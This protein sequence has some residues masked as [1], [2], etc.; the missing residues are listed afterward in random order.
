MANYNFRPTNRE[1]SFLMPPS[2]KEWLPEDDLVWFVIDAVK[3]IDLRPFYRKYRQDGKGNTAYEPAMMVMLL[4]YAYCLGVRSI[5]KIERLC[6]VD[7]GFRVIAGNQGPDHSTLCRFRQGNRKHIGEL[8]THILQLCAE[9]GLVKLGLVALDGVKIKANAA[10]SANRG[11]SSIEKEVE[12][13]L[14]EAEEI[15]AAEDD[16]YGKGKRGDELPEEL[17]ERSSRLQR[18][19]EAK[20][21][22]ERKQDEE[23]R[24]QEEM[25][26]AREEE[27]KKSGK[28]KRGRKPKKPEEAVNTQTKANITDPESRI[29][30]KRTGY[31]QAYNSQLV[32]T[33]DQIIIAADVTQEENDKKQLHPMLQQAKA[34]LKKAGVGKGIRTLLADAGYWSEK[35]IQAAEEDGPE[36]LIAT[37]KDWKQQKVFREM[38]APRGRIPAGI[39]AR[40]RMERKLRTKKAKERYKQRGWMVEGVIGQITDTR[41]CDQFMLRGEEM[42]RSEWRLIAGSHN[43]LKL[44]RSGKAKWRVE[45]A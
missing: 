40:E 34:E 38:G 11:L 30:K 12:R 26:R 5:R 18:L 43:L 42:V 13:I 37:A 16:L 33:E 4:I 19:Q 41:D 32:V 25:I 44:W 29:M 15:D 8:F 27:E 36:L 2:M 9:A 17:R 3:Q 20:E 22:L 28:K 24:Q 23:A 7:V 6:Q 21:R 35:N 14:Q 39:S 31:L 45:T 1:Q 10:L